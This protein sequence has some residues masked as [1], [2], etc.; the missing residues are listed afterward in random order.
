MKDKK[1]I[2]ERI[3]Y[4]KRQLEFTYSENEYDRVEARIDELENVLEDD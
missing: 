2:L 1:W 4:L 3:D